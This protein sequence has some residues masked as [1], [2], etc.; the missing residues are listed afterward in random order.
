MDVFDNIPLDLIAGELRR[1]TELASGV[2]RALIG[3]G[4]GVVT[5]AAAMKATAQKLTT[6]AVI[7]GALLGLAYGMS[8][9]RL[10]DRARRG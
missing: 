5:T 6:P 4:L 8:D 3:V 2:E 1:R 7:A 10:L 9:K